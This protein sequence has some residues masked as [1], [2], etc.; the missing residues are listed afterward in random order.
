MEQHFF[1]KLQTRSRGMLEKI[2]IADMQICSSGTTFLLEVADLKL[3][4]AEK[5][6]LADMPICSC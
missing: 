5:I 1:K 6:V 4:N 3:R 2:V